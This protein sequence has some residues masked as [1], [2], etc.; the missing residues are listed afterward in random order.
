[1]KSPLLVSVLCSAMLLYLSYIMK[2]FDALCKLLYANYRLDGPRSLLF[3]G[4][5]L[6]VP[7][8]FT[9]LHPGRAYPLLM[10][11]RSLA[12]HTMFLPAHLPTAW[13]KIIDPKKIVEE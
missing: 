6:L 2:P 9:Y 5:P 11:L 10:L 3:L 13:L 12:T 4:K 8:L 7:S 1:M